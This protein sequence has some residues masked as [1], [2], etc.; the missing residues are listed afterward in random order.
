MKPF[1]NTTDMLKNSLTDIA[2]MILMVASTLAFL[3]I[4]IQ[5]HLAHTGK[6][7]QPRTEA[8]TLTEK[9][10]GSPYKPAEINAKIKSS[11]LLTQGK[12]N[13]EH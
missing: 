2:L 12:L 9:C 6:G 13:D 3:S 8:A 4:V 1:T 11:I 5:S 7:D 10:V